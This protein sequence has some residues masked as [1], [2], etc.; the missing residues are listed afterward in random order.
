MKD[1][2]EPDF[3]SSF[4]DGFIPCFLFGLIPLSI[5]NAHGGEQLLAL[6][7]DSQVRLLALLSLLNGLLTGALAL[8]ISIKRHPHR[9][10]SIARRLHLYAFLT[11]FLSGSVGI[12]L[13]ISAKSVFALTALTVAV[14]WRNLRRFG[15]RVLHLLHPK[16]IPTWS[17]AGFLLQTYLTTIGAF[18][19]INAA[20]DILYALQGAS[21][22]PFSFV[23]GPGMIIDS[24]YFSTVVV[25]TLGF[26]DIVPATLDG[27]V[28]V[29]LECM[30][31]Y[32]MF[33]LTIGVVTKG[34]VKSAPE[35]VGGK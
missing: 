24:L 16:V 22:A 32:L 11:G 20:L 4:C 29:T 8:F 27:K 23:H 9:Q 18:T 19:L 33:A 14:I 34:V 21:P 2:A 17:D 25:T 12:A 1:T 26:G 5:L 31:G 10:A 15:S 28:L 6:L 13:I 7:G 30:I 3:L 35:E